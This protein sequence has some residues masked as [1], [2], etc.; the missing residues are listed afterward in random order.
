MWREMRAKGTEEDEGKGCGGMGAKGV[1][2]DGG[3]GYKGG[4]G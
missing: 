3:K 4:W 2:E 1:E